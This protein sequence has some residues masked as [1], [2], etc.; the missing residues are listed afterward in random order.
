MTQDQR[1]PSPI[2]AGEYLPEHAESPGSVRYPPVSTTQKLL[3][4]ITQVLGVSLYRL[5]ALLGRGVPGVYQWTGS[6]P[7]TMK[8][9]NPVYMARL[10][11]LLV[12]QAQGFGV[13]MFESIDWSS[14]VITVMDVGG[15]HAPPNRDSLPD[16]KWE[17]S[18]GSKGLGDRGQE[19]RGWQKTGC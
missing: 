14:G 2:G 4:E 17:F 19:D 13:S 16:G 1:K 15:N 9:P 10:T 5:N 8:R 7:S 18:K 12:M 6:S 3:V 11:K